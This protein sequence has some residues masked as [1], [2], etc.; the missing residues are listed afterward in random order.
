MRLSL[1]AGIRLASV[2][3]IVFLARVAAQPAPAAEVAARRPNVVLILTD[4]QG[5]GDLGI[6]GNTV[7]KT[8]NI[9]RLAGE[10]VMFRNF[11][12]AP[13]C[14]PSRASL[15]T[16]RYHQR[17]GVPYADGPTDVL[18]LR[19]VTIARALKGA[20]YKTALIGKWHLGRFAV[21]GPL[22]HG[23]DLFF[24]FRDGM[25]TFYNDAILEQNGKPVRTNGY[26][27]DV[28]TDA[29]LRFVEENRTKPFFLFLSYNAPHLPMKVPIRYEEPYNKPGISAHL[30]KL[31]GMITHLDM[32]IGRVLTR[33]K[34]LEIEDNTIVIFLSDNGAQKGTVGFVKSAE[35][36]R[37][38][39]L[40]RGVDRFNAGLRG[41]KG[42]VYEGGVR[43][44]FIARWP[45]RFPK[46]KVVDSLAA[47][48]DL[49][50]TILE[51]ADVPV[52]E[53][54]QLDGKSIAHI[55]RSGEGARV[56]EKLFLWCDP[57]ADYHTS[58]MTYPK[59]NY[60]VRSGPWKLVKGTELYNLD[61]DPFESR[62]VI[63]Q[64]QEI[65]RELKMAFDIWSEDVI[66]RE[67]LQPLPIPID[68]EDTP[69]YGSNIFRGGTLV[70][71]RWAQLHG[72][73]G[74]RFAYNKNIRDR[75]TDWTSPTDYISWPVDVLREGLYEV[76]LQY[77]CARSDAGSRIRISAGDS[78]LEA[79]VEPTPAI[80]VWQDW[81]V[82]TLKLT[83]ATKR[84]TIRP[85]SIA[86]PHVMDLR[87][88]RLKWVGPE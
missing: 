47:H 27:T 63:D 73:G 2:L 50:P 85:L 59:N 60:A 30:A 13:I 40:W 62:N 12:M 37:L 74:I 34:E 83:R 52:P 7:L 17:T 64:R 33:L 79:V 4:D 8:P 1:H 87:E 43:V 78:T 16:G 82:G 42:T 26:V 57:A 35:S 32:S 5:Y 67:D 18:R 3:A 45:N 81:N 76:V 48:I 24:G 68:G 88:V 75:L 19:E 84:L 77:G 15:L 71:L 11:Y 66:P 9:D 39:E 70:T 41:Q 14:A 56:H 10:G 72:D 46:A 49:L 21:N 65:A 80:D 31:Y 69:S 23:F 29:A 36:D 20:G 6:T 28:L 54:L 22:A 38:D 86:G 44:P 61:E 53:G 25:I 55:L 51:L 58:R